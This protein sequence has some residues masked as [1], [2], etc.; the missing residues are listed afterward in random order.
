LK[1]EVFF[2]EKKNQK[3]FALWRTRSGGLRSSA[4]IPESSTLPALEHD[5]FRLLNLKR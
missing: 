4:A 5:R 3:T 1:E 2:F